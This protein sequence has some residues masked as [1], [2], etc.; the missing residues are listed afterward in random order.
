VPASVLSFLS[1]DEHFEAARASHAL[2]E[3][4][5]LTSSWSLDFRVFRLIYGVR[6]AMSDW[7]RAEK[8][9]LAQAAS[10]RVTALRGLLEMEH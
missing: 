6:G 9:L 7:N 5:K 1:E 8:L 10:P 4:A 3:A 2:H